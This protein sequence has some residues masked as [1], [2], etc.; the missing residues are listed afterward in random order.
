MKRIVFIHGLESILS[1]E[2]LSILSKYGEVYAPI[3]DYKSNSNVIELLLNDDK[4][5]GAD[6]I[7]GSSMGGFMAF[8]LS[9]FFNIPALL[10]NP[11]LYKRSVFQEISSD[12]LIHPSKKLIVLGKQ[13][14]VVSNEEVILF[15]NTND[16]NENIQ[17]IY[18]EDMGH[19][20]PKDKFKKFSHI[21]FNK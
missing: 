5:S 9:S 4:I 17:V 18:E 13:D 1:E 7:I 8:Y 12:L 3:V 15:L 10:Y 2:K 20:I 16:L 14:D 19:R 11:A 21:F 6:F